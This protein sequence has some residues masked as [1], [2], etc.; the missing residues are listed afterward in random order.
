MVS[1]KYQSVAQSLAQLIDNGTLKPGERFPS[2]RRTMRGYS[3]SLST[4]NQA[5][6]HLEDKGYIR[7]QAKSGYFVTRP[8]SHRL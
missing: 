7:A 6:A 3:V 1:F 4:A 5:Y 8:A 2:L